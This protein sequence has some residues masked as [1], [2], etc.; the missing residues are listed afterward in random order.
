[1][2]LPALCVTA[3]SGES[4]SKKWRDIEAAVGRFFPT[5]LWSAGRV[6]L[7]APVVVVATLVFILNRNPVAEQGVYLGQ[8][9][10]YA[11]FLLG[12]ESREI[13][14]YPMWGYPFA[15]A[16]LGDIPLIALQFVLA[17][18]AVSMVFARIDA[19]KN[20]GRWS[21]LFVAL[22]TVPWF[23][24]ASL[25]SAMAIAIPLLWISAILFFDALDSTA[26]LWPVAIAGALF[27][28][29]LNF[30]S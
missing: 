12:E 10:P 6:G 26:K 25:N 1:M 8:Y 15:I 5:A 13:L 4:V 23:A 3:T 17:L 28:L 11:R 2:E 14:T 7:M 22:L 19:G 9:V 16:M 21:R 27:G 30:R 20:L 24:L 18:V 29:A